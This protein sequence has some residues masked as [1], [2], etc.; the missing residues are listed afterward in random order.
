MRKCENR[1]GAR[2]EKLEENSD[3]FKFVN[4]SDRQRR[5]RKMLI[6]EAT[7]KMS[8]EAE[9]KMVPSQRDVSLNS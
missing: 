7:S 5:K 8:A 2:R 6:N 9:S 4:I 3:R 1:A